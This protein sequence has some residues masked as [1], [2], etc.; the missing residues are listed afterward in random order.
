LKSPA[1]PA[2]LFLER[3]PAHPLQH[4]GSNHGGARVFEESAVTFKKNR[5]LSNLCER[6]MDGSFLIL[7][8]ALLILAAALG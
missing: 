6:L 4:V 7:L 2:G 3:A 8:A 5:M 1:D